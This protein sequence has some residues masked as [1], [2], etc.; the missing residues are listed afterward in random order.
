MV[1]VAP[2]EDVHSPEFERP[3]HPHKG[4]QDRRLEPQGGLALIMECKPN[5]YLSCAGKLTDLILLHR[6]EPTHVDFCPES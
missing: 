5:G 3:G 6:V 1:K 4:I 2:Q